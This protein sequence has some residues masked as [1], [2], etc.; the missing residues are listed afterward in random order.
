MV[1]NFGMH[2]R[3]V[4]YLCLS[5]SLFY[6]FDFKIIWDPVINSTSDLILIDLL[7]LGILTTTFAVQSLY[8][9]LLVPY[10]K[11]NFS[12]MRLM[13]VFSKKLNLIFNI[14]LILLYS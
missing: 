10:A 14:N 2:V 8:F 7:P 3:G 9:V 1:P 11:L 5:F 4:F 13:H 12:G 6:T